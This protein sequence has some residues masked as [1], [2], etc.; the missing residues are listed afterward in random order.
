MRDWI[1]I[2]EISD[3]DEYEDFAVLI[4]FQGEIFTDTRHSYDI[5]NDD[6]VIYFVPL[7]SYL[8]SEIKEQ[9]ND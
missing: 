9:I 6:D 1:D 7:H 4:H 2:K 3:Y 8:S 5:L